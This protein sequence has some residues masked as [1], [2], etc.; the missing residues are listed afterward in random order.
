MADMGWREPAAKES[1]H[2]LP[3]NTA[4]LAPSSEYLV[5]ELSHGEAKVGEGVPITRHSVVADM[6]AH[7]SVQ[8]LADFRNR[9][10]H[11]LPQFRFYCLQLGLQPFSDG[12]PQHG[13]SALAGSPANVRETQKGERFRLPETT[14]FSVAGR[15]RA[16]L[17]KP[18]LFRVQFQLELSHAFGELLPELLGFPSELESQHDV[19]G[20]AHH[21]DLAARTLLPPC[22]DPQVEN[23]VEI[24]IR[25][26]GRS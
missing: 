12:L 22:L 7:D 11:A 4:F 9:I 14:V 23:V 13:E 6:P 24:E 3:G 1:F 10:V 8:P 18:G 25:Q 16:E 20:K 5:P 2:S 17:Q 21:D 19:V 26:Q 15:K